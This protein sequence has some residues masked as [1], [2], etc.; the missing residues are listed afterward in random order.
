MASLKLSKFILDNTINSKPTIMKIFQK[1][2][3]LQA[4]R[5][6]V[7][8]QELFDNVQENVEDILRIIR[9]NNMK[10]A[11]HIIRMILKCNINLCII[12]QN[13]LSVMW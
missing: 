6:Y 2:C 11:K 5:A 1:T 3:L 7:L 10:V 12:I 13:N 9:T 4:N 8:I